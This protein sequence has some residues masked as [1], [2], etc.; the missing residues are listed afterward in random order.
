MHAIPRA[1]ERTGPRAGTREWAG[2]AALV[3]PTLLLSMD[4]TV[5]FL[6]LPV[7]GAELGA[8]AAQQLWIMDAYGFMIAGFL[9]TMGT[10]GDRIGRRRLLLASAAAFALLSALAAWS[11]GPGMLIVLRALL[12]IAGATIMPATLSLIRHMFAD[13]RQRRLAIAFWTAGTMGGMA[14]GP[15]TGGLLL[16]RYWWGAVFLM[17]VPVMLLVLAAGP[18]L[19]EYRDPVPGR[20]DPLSVALSLAATLPLVYAIKETARHGPDA[21]T[22]TALLAGLVSAYLFVRRQ[23]RLA[24][25]L[26][27][28]RLLRLPAFAP[29]LGTLLA[30]SMTMGAF[31]LLLAQY[32]Q[33]V[34][35][36]TPAQA[37]AWLVPGALVSVLA[38]LATPR[39]AARFGDRATTVGTLAVAGAGFTL[40][41]QVSAGHPTIAAIAAAAVVNAGMSPLLVLV[42]NLVIDIA[43]KER[44][45]SAAAMSETSLQAGAALG[46]AVLGSLAALVYRTRMAG[47]PAAARDSLAA[48]IAGGPPADLLEAARA[49]FVSGLTT[50]AYLSAAIAFALAAFAIR[51][52]RTIRKEDHH[53]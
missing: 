48:A 12:G 1:A 21:A 27:D 25:P 35:G 20:L 37:G 32:L 13:D 16:D 3:L 14:L 11:T 43:P 23:S 22:L 50:V 42:N 18:L 45:A 5:L 38:M 52:I 15:A 51:T 47:G 31:S 26:L 19:P 39:A 36:L 2:L 34:K 8:D 7:L 46:V 53:V 24:A 40:L 33:L 49:A 10:L 4:V 28:L 9:V 30:A 17:A 44:S 29:V 6:A 41:A